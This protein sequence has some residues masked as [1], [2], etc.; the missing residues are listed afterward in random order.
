MYQVIAVILAVAVA[1]IVFATFWYTSYMHQQ[2]MRLQSEHEAEMQREL[3]ACL[4]F[5]YTNGVLKFPTPVPWTVYYQ[6]NPTASGY[7]MEVDGLQ[8]GYTVAVGYT[9]YIEVLPDGKAKAYVI[10]QVS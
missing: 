6:G 5:N 7:G 10:Q 2:A 9:C 3:Y 4:Y 1:V 8:P